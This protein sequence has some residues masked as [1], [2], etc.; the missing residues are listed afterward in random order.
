MNLD[1]FAYG[2]G[3]LINIKYFFNPELPERIKAIQF[4]FEHDMFFI[5]VNGEDDTLEITH[6]SLVEPFGKEGYQNI[7]VSNEM[8]W[9]LAINNKVAWLW[10]MINQQNY[11]DGFQM[12]F[13]DKN[14]NK[15]STTIQMLA[16]LSEIEISMV[17]KLTNIY[18]FPTLKPDK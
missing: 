4:I 10:M 6:E 16:V 2:N 14:N 15:N 17:S 13:H 7:D 1:T 5:I 9:K 3:E 18:H 12:E 8:P 11:L